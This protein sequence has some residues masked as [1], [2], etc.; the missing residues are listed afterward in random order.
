MRICSYHI[1]FLFH[2][3]TRRQ[4]AKSFSSCLSSGFP[5]DALLST[6][7][8]LFSPRLAVLG[9]AFG[10]FLWVCGSKDQTWEL[11]QVRQVLSHWVTPHPLTTL[12]PHCGT[13]DLTQ[14]L[15]RQ[16]HYY[17]VISLAF[18]SKFKTAGFKKSYEQKPFCEYI[19]SNEYIGNKWK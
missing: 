14:G 10:E 11:I 3:H 19:S 6:H 13:R 5:F 7:P 12:Q 16:L 2:H 17:W 18:N 4:T 15:A 1:N 8:P 9:M